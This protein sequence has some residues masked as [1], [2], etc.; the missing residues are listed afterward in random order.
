VILQEIAWGVCVSGTYRETGGDRSLPVTRGD[1]IKKT[2]KGKQNPVQ[3]RYS[4]S[5]YG[6]KPRSH[7][8]KWG[9]I[10]SFVWEGG[11]EKA[12]LQKCFAE[13]SRKKKNLRA[14]E[15][16]AFITIPTHLGKTDGIRSVASEKTDNNGRKREQRSE[17]R[18]KRVGDLEG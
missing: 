11:R 17:H 18:S 10:I 8:L 7:L 4:Q 13:E 5:V 2:K 3:I 6:G 1:I 16:I 12:G 14:K 9:R 15:V